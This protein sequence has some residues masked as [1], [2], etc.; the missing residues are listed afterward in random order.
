MPY[1]LKSYDT[2][3][4]LKF[5]DLNELSNNTDNCK[6]S[7]SYKIRYVKQKNINFIS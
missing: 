5:A 4:H 7:K 6:V 1:D 3:G 2:L